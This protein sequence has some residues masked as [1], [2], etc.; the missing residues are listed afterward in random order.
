MIWGICGGQHCFFVIG[1]FSAEK[2]KKLTQKPQKV[3]FFLNFSQ[4]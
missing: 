2:I 4:E 1:H 3:V